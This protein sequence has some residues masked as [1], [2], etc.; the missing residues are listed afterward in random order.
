MF[1]FSFITQEIVSTNN[2][3]NYE[4]FSVMKDLNVLQQI[5]TSIRLTPGGNQR[6]HDVTWQ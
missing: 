4:L 3:N 1:G 6:Q 5:A 2:M